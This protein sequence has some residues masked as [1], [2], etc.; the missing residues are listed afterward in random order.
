MQIVPNPTLLRNIWFYFKVFKEL[1]IFWI[2]CRITVFVLTIAGLVLLFKYAAY[3]PDN[4]NYRRNYDDTKTLHRNP[5]TEA[6]AT[7]KQSE[8]DAQKKNR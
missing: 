6:P 5:F 8:I 4:P 2:I 3:I 7:M 1:F